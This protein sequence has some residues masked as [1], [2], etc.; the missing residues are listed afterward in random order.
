MATEEWRD[1]SGFP[2]YQVSSFGRVR[3]LKHDTPKILSQQTMR[4]KNK[5]PYVVTNLWQNSHYHRCATCRLVAEAFLPNPNNFPDICH[6]DG[7]PFNNHLENLYWTYDQNKIIAPKA[8][9]AVETGQIFSSMRQA[10]KAFSVDPARIRKVV[11]KPD[12]KCRGVHFV[13]L[14][15]DELEEMLEEQ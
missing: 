13:H 8:V 1:I 12:N 5:S 11:D 14:T 7:D 10:G 6:R 9:K 2:K 15:L 3:S 4:I